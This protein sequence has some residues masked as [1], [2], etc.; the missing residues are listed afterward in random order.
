MPDSRTIRSWIS[1][2]CG[3]DISHL[4]PERDA[5]AHCRGAVP[6]L[7]P[8]M[9]QLGFGMTGRTQ[10]NDHA[11]G[12][13]RLAGHALGG[14]SAAAPARIS[15]RAGLGRLLSTCML[16]MSALFRPY[17]PVAAMFAVLI[18]GGFV[19]SLQF[20]A[21]NTI[22]YADVPRAQMSAATSFYT[23]FQQLS[24]NLGI[25]VSAATLAASITLAGH[26][27][28]LPSDFSAAFV[29]VALIALFAR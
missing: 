1:A 10:R 20:M 5:V 12:F 25:G 6:F 4:R 24:L 18:V 26:D 23:T 15:Q 16:A 28:P 22:A 19:Q 7:L 9:L 2:S 13:D 3:S 14:A 29:V 27:R 17:W 11:R 8:M 21:Y